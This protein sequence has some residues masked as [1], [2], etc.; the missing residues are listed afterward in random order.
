VLRRSIEVNRIHSSARRGFTLVELLVVIGIIAILISV[1]LPT[2]ASARRSANSVKCLASLREIGN[3]FNLYA[4][5]NKGFYP[6]VRDTQLPPPVTER[7]WTDQIAKYISK[8]GRDFK[9]QADI[10]KIRRNSVLWG[11]PEW[12][13]SYD[14]SASNSAYAG[15]NVYNGY[16]M[17]YNPGY[18]DKNTTANS[19]YRSSTA[20]LG[21]LRQ[22]F[23]GR[24]A[25]ERLLVADSVVDY[26]QLPP[27]G[28]NKATVLLQPWNPAPA[29]SN[30]D[31]TIDSRHMKAGTSKKAALTQ[32][33][34]N[35]L[36]VDG[37][38]A[39]VS[40]KDAYNAI[41]NPGG[42]TAK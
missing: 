39:T 28:F 26:I 3:A 11:C 24:R 31:F 15:V 20:R 1:L 40:A 13:R 38:A 7:R 4:S 17:Q 34:I 5:E 19:A 16:G 14:W 6:A 29:Y 25:A 33:T 42:D 21:Y 27:G 18:P 35:A 41:R 9:D 23:W 2:L 22:S 30:D 36:F 8:A 12:T 10:A 37:H 32:N